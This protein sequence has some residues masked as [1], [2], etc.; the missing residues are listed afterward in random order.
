[1][2]IGK[3]LKQVREENGLSQTEIAQKLGINQNTV[4]SWEVGRTQPKHETIITLC[5]LYGCTYEHLTGT[6][7]HDKGDVSLTDILAKLPELSLSDL[8]AI[9]NACFFEIKAAKLEEENKRLS[10]MVAEY[11]KEIEKLKGGTL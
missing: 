9:V 1:M 8:E 7:Q 4:S 3:R 10:D 11:Q 5:G 2:T 6:K